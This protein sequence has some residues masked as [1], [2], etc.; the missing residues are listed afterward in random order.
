M[1][2]DNRSKLLLHYK[3]TITIMTDT[4]FVEVVTQKVVQKCKN[5]KMDKRVNQ[6]KIEWII[7]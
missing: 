7:E 3:Q 2:D 5:V 4:F 1:A 6:K